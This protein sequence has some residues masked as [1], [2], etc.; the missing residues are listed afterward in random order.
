MTKRVLVT[1]AS[2]LIGR[3]VLEILRPHY[4]PVALVR[5]IET[6]SP[7]VEVIAADLSEPDFMTRLPSRM[8]GVIHLAQSP[9]F[10]RFPECA[11]QVFQVN[12]RALSDLLNWAQKAG[13]GSF[14]HA[15]TGGLY[16][17]AARPFREEDPSCLEGALAHYVSTKAAAELI[18]SAYSSVFNV[19]A[20][21][22]FFVYGEG[23]KK[24]MLFPRL[25]AA[26]STGAPVTLAGADGMRLNPVYVDDAAAATVAALRLTGKTI[27]NVAGSE[28]LSMREIAEAIGAIV[29]KSPI[30][31]ETQEADGD[32]VADISRMQT[33]L[34]RPVVQFRDGI[35][36]VLR[37]TH[38]H[39]DPALRRG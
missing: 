35:R 25:A 19:T 39:E 28:V 16:G 27:V 34:H 1:G 30:F 38:T 14:V 23:Q 5:N 29:G 17:R 7:D 15:S 21:R 18:A 31:Q 26:V 10:S 6:T 20:L 22:F 37:A 24:T 4:D 32:L 8:D 11:P 3:R 33:L 12:V 36:R 2:G 13:V 9:G